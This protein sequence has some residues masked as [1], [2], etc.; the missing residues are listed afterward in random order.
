M[1]LKVA[2]DELPALNLTPMIDVV[3]LLVIFFMVATQFADA[4]RQIDLKVPSVK[5]AGALTP[6][7]KKQ[8]VNVFA[9]GRCHLNGKEMDLV[10]LTQELAHIKRQY[11]ELGVLVR[12][13]GECRF[14]VVAKVL[15][16]CG[17][18]RIADTSIAVRVDGNAA[19]R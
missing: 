19:R 8:V 13:D 9:N 7:P 10:G 2:R 14:D 3:L 15:A 16:A 18:A 17:K 12:G 5:E 4:E 6:A 1:P 11:P